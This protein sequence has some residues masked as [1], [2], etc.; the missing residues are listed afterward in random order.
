MFN[1]LLDPLPEDWHGYPIDSD[2]QTGIMISQCLEDL[3][4]N[5]SEKFITAYELLFPD[6]NNRPPLDEAESAINWYMNEFNHDNIEN[7]GHK[8]KKGPVIMDYDIDQ[9]RIYSA[10]LKQY[11]IDLN[12]A[13]MHWFVFIGLLL[14]LEECNFTRVMDIRN[15]KIT[16]KM[17]KEEKKHI[18][19]AKK[20]YSIMRE[21]EEVFSEKEQKAI[22][23]FLKYAGIQEKK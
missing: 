4:L 14:N 23:N 8:E 18:A 21:H 5:E 16:P 22:D 13:D 17:S 15:K 9:W 10:F 11:G 19:A 12:S 7:S 1:V 20:V 2:F 6:E 3:E